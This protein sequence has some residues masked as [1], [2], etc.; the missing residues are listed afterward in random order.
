MSS[1]LL[2]SLFGLA[3]VDATSFGTGGVPVF[4]AI[5]RTPFRRLAVYLAT[6]TGFYF[7]VG[8]AVMLGADAVLDRFGDAF[9]SRAAYVVQLLIGLA[10]IGG[11]L[12]VERRDKEAKARAEAGEPVSARRWQPR[13]SS[14]TAMVVLALTAGVIEVASMVPYLSAIGLLTTTD[15]SIGERIGTLAAYSLVMIAPAT[16]L[17][18]VAQVARRFV[19]PLLTRLG[20]WLEKNA[21]EMLLWALWIVGIVL[22]FNAL[23]P[24]L[25]AG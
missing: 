25:G 19:E 6:I 17:V 2:L 23:G 20:R 12:I 8:V 24:V 5:A 15:L 22:I 21:S 14:V 10:L 4:L 1:G 3:L 9:E 16:A 18:A 13:D 11:A 7:L